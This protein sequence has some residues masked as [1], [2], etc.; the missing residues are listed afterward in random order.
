V[1][2]RLDLAGGATMDVGCYAIHQIRAVAAAEPEVVRARPKI[3]APGID[4]AMTAGFTFAGGLTADM[5]IALLEARAPMA[6]L[7]V[8]GD[9]GRVVVHFPTR[10]ELAWITIR[11]GGRTRR[12]RV[13]GNSTF[14]YQLAAFSGS[15][16]R[17]ELVLTGPGDAVATMRVI[18]AVYRAA[19]LGPRRPSA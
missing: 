15:V 4:R 6:D 17:G 3:A 2:Y 16:Q 18:D 19:E 12:E 7:R 13:K 5:E 10:P 11:I 8:T 14:W 1:R 9:A